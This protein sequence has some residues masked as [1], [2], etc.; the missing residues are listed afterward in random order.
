MLSYPCHLCYSEVYFQSNWS[1]DRAH[2][3]QGVLRLRKRL[4]GRRRYKWQ[5]R[6][7]LTHQEIFCLSRG[8][9]RGPCIFQVFN[10]QKFMFKDRLFQFI[11]CNTCIQNS[12]CGKRFISRMHVQLNFSRGRIFKSPSIKIEEKENQL[13][14]T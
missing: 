4:F 8:R 5:S 12:I 7:P 10:I 1:K 2:K 9:S 6:N 11:T 13:L 3:N 14:Y